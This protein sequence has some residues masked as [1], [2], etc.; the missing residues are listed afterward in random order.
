MRKCFFPALIL[1]STFVFGQEKALHSFSLNSEILEDSVKVQM[2]VPSDIKN[3]EVSLIVLL[4]GDSY[5]GFT[6]DIAHL[7]EY[8]EITPSLVVVS[9]PSTTKSRW[10]YY[11]PTQ[12]E[13]N[14][15]YS[16]SKELF[17]LTGHFDGFAGFVSN[18]LIPKLEKDLAIKF[19]SKT[20][21]GHSLGGLGA[22]GFLVLKPEIFDNY[23]IASPSSFYDDFY[24]IDKMKKFEKLAYKNLYI[25]VSGNE[26]NGY[27]GNTIY[28]YE[29]LKEREIKS[30]NLKFKWYENQSHAEVGLSSLLDGLRFI[31]ENQ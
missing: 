25:T 28:I 27:I 7:Y 14:P 2:R 26:S 16:N 23:I 18:E 17:E 4:D 3:K 29:E 6:K 24:I 20:I 31:Y 12:E 15:Q 13:Y 21:F 5:F 8:A 10:K 19:D 11:T 30:N 9:L 22:M 1:F